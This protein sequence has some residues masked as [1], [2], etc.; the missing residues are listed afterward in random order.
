M[1]LLRSLFHE[2]FYDVKFTIKFQRK[3]FLGR[4]VLTANLIEVKLASSKYFQ[5]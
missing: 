4:E 5:K 2:D 1:R 3:C